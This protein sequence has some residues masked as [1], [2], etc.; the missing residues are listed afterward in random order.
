MTNDSSPKA[1]FLTRLESKLHALPSHERQKS[2][3]YYKN[4]LSNAQDES[5]AIAALG[6]PSDVA[7]DILASYL[8]RENAPHAEAPKKCGF[9][10]PIWLI[11]IL[12][13]FGLPLILGLGGGLIGLVAGIASAIFAFL[14]SGVSMF[15]TGIV[16][17]IFSV[18]IIFQDVGFGLIVAGAGLVLIGL[19]ILFFKFAIFIGKGIF[20]ALSLA[21]RRLRHGRFA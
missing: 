1:D 6:H 18:F 2:L 12:I 19:G 9:N 11:V 8:K 21:I 10:M 4:Y 7:A 15:F 14:V 20:A 13:I 16:S 3:E 5:A 17:V